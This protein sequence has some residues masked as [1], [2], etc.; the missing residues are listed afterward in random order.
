MKDIIVIA[1]YI[2]GAGPEGAIPRPICSIYFQK[3]KKFISDS[4]IDE[5][6][7]ESHKN[8]TIEM[9]LDFLKSDHNPDYSGLI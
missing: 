9:V 2:T 5:R 3:D 4:L 8:E 1:E 7:N 6:I